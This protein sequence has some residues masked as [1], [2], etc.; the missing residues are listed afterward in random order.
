[1]PFPDES[2][3]DQVRVLPYQ[4]RWAAE[5]ADL[6][7]RLRLLVPDATAVDH[8]GST[9]VPGLPA[10]DCID[11]MVRV[12]SL[13]DTDLDAL[14]ADGFRERPEHWN[15]EETLGAAKYTKRVFAPPAGGRAMNIHVREVG[16]GTARY[17]LL[18]RDYLRADP[19]SRVVWGQFKIRLAETATDIYSYGQIKSTVQP[20]LMTLA[21]QWADNTAWRP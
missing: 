21:E 7:A 13:N 8:M 1:M 3:A 16:S 4:V 19:T 11:A 20:L 6:V 15:H 14:L 17:A 18:F 10:K 5:G 2:F 12:R 9:S